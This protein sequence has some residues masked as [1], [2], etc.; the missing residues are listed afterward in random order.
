MTRRWSK[1]EVTY[2]KRYHKRKN[3]DELAQHFTTEVGTVQ[4]KLRELGLGPNAHPTGGADPQLAVFEKAL[5]A[6]HAGNWATAI[7]SLETV[8]AQSEQ[9]EL[10][11]RGRQ[12]LDYCRRQLDEVPEAEADPYLRA[13]VL[14][15]RGELEASLDLCL[16]PQSRR[17]DEA[18]AYLAAGI[19]A[20][21]GDHEAAAERLARAID[22]NP[23]NRIQAG[24]DPEFETLRESEEHSALF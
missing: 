5:K 1:T 16:K 20:L 14:R 4:A 10:A 12:Y 23:K 24:Y 7:R 19:H 8:V 21:Q 22:L 15:N 13:V 17:E 18:F 11:A 9:L 6:L 3:A 2:L